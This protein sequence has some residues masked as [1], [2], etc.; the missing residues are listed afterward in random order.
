MPTIENAYE[1][2]HRSA[3]EIIAEAK[4][5]FKE[6]GCDKYYLS[7]YL[8]GVMREAYN[9]LALRV[10]IAHNQKIKS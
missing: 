9:T 2:E 5:R 8:L 4:V 3:E 10:D 1:I 6:E 7:A